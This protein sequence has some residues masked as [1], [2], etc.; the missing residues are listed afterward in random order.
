MSICK[1]DYVSLHENF[2]AENETMLAKISTIKYER[3]NIMTYN[4]YYGT[5]V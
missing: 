3:K 2:V 5:M 4:A 1:N